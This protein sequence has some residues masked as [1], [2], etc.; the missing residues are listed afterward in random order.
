M[1]QIKLTV[2]GLET[3]RE[4]IQRALVGVPRKT[5]EV[6]AR[7]VPRLRAALVQHSSGHP[8]PGV[9]TGAYNA[10]YD[11]HL[12]DGGMSVVAGNPSPQSNRLEYGF[13]GADAMGRHYAQPPFPHF[14][15]TFDEVA[16]AYYIDIAQVFGSVW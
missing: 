5:R 6:N 7:W 10:A 8:G 11:V 13:V 15:P 12:T 14:R 4:R 9:I 16:P 3:L 2:I 1:P